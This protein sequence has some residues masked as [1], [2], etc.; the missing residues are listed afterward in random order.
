MFGSLGAVALGSERIVA[1]DVCLH[2]LKILH[3][4]LFILCICDGED[5]V[6]E[7]MDQQS[8][9]STLYHCPN[10]FLLEPL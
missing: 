3:E 6:H 10:E 5:E 1:L 4:Y 7:S 2:C 9:V 8:D